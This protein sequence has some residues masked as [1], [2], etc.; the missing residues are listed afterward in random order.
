[1]KRANKANPQQAWN[2]TTQMVSKPK[3][4]ASSSLDVK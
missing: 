4:P 2:N 1:M 3:K